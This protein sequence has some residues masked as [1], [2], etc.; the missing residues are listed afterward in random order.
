MY[1]LACMRFHMR[2]YN[3][4]C[5]YVCEGNQNAC[6]M[7][8]VFTVNTW[9]SSA[10]QIS[11]HIIS[12]IC[13]INV[14]YFIFIFFLSD[15]KI[16]SIIQIGYFFHLICLMQSIIHDNLNAACSAGCK[17]NKTIIHKNKI[18]SQFGWQIQSP[19]GIWHDI[20]F[21]LQIIK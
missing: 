3:A 4:E 20:H 17:N 6:L 21:S 12:F 9:L 2:F 14:N 8:F 18:N 13:R 16:I 11:L 7:Q 15:K 5:V 10:Y 19:I 1:I